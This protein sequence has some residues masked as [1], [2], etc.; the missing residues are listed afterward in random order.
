LLSSTKARVRA[1]NKPAL[2]NIVAT[3]VK[4]VDEPE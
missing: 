1:L 3:Q 4:P 2:N